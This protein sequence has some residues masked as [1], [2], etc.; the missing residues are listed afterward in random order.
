M[1]WDRD[2]PGTLPGGFPRATLW[3]QPTPRLAQAH[4]LLL[5]A[6]HLDDEPFVAAPI[7]LA[8]QDC[9]PRPE[10]EPAVGDRDDDLVVHQQV[11]EVGV[12]VV[13]AAAM[14]AI[15]A[16]VGKQLPGDVVG[17]RLPGR[18]RQ[19]VEPL[20]R[21]GLDAGLVV[22]D[23]HAGGDVHRRDQRHALADPG[24]VDG[25]RS[26]ASPRTCGAPSTSPGSARAWRWS[27]R[28][29]SQPECGSTTTSPASRPTRSSGSTSWRRRPGSR[30]P[31][32]SPGSCFPTAATIAT[33]AAAKTTATPISRT[34][35][36]TIRSSSRSPR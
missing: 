29:T 23:P 25:A 24:L 11:L 20:E 31:T 26:C 14:V 35:W 13:F 36:C 21:V 10:V 3:A 34:C 33:I 7:E 6:Q 18:R 17:R 30:R 8:V 19:L 1:D 2:S 16:A 12:A 22:V 4:A 9:L 32:T 27:R 5:L 15:V 28:C